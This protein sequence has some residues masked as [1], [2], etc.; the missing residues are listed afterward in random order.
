M[1][2]FEGDRGMV[3]KMIT[4]MIIYGP[5]LPLYIVLCI[6]LIK[7]WDFETIS[8]MYSIIIMAMLI[9]GALWLTLAV[10]LP[11]AYLIFG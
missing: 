11:L 7:E 1:L 5:A 10:F 8:T 2:I 4:M 9:I 3:E 6:K